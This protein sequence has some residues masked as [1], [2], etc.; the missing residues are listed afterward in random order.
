[1]EGCMEFIAE[2]FMEI[3]VSG[4]YHLA[5]D[6]SVPKWGRLLARSLFWFGLL[7]ALPIWGAVSLWN[8]ARVWSGVLTAIAG[9]GILFGLVRGVMVFFPSVRHPGI[10]KEL[11]FEGNPFPQEPPASYCVPFNIRMKLFTVLFSCIGIGLLVA[12]AYLLLTPNPT[13]PRGRWLLFCAITVINAGILWMSVYLL[14]RWIGKKGMMTLTPNGIENAVVILTLC[15]FCTSFRT[16]L[17]PW[18]AVTIGK[19]KAFIK[20]N[21]AR[22]PFRAS[23]PLRFALYT[24]GIP[25]CFCKITSEALSSYRT[26][27]LNSRQI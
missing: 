12:A 5:T 22:L 23:P 8:I 20:V 14:I 21:T 2:L 17:I 6:L 11:H 25:L 19:S 3:F 1:M 10:P 18:E 13:D 15:A 27:A 9:I 7:G 24:P 16:P 4:W 26:A